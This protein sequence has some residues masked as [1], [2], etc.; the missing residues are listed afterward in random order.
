MV[1]DT[2]ESYF[3]I[4]IVIVKFIYRQRY[5]FSRIYPRRILQNIFILHPCIRPDRILPHI[6]HYHCNV[7]FHLLYHSLQNMHI[8]CMLHH[9]PSISNNHS[10]PYHDGVEKH[11]QLM[12]VYYP[13]H[14]SMLLH[15][16]E[17]DRSLM[18]SF[19]VRYYIL[20]DTSY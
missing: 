18:Q 20:Y 14:C 6:V 16:K 1:S 13:W 7:L 2:F 8:S 3:A 9:N 12:T 17:V 11:S 15:D 10:R 19:P 5:P 4:I